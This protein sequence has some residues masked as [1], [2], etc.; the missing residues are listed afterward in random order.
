MQ[1]IFPPNLVCPRRIISLFPLPDHLG[2]LADELAAAQS[3]ANRMTQSA[4]EWAIQKDKA[5]EAYSRANNWPAIKEAFQAMT[6]NVRETLVNPWFGGNVVSET[7]DLEAI[8]TA[9]STVRMEEEAA[10]QAWLK[11]RAALDVTLRSA[12]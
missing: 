6:E 9:A 10:R 2:K 12:R 3:S 8:A 11:K 7:D 4:S 5:T 1:F